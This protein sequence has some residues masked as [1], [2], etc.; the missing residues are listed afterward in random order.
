MLFK[1]VRH[2]SLFA[3]IFAVGLTF[4]Y[5]RFAVTP[6]A[7]SLVISYL[8]MPIV[9]FFE[10]FKVSRSITAIIIIF[11]IL[12][13]GFYAFA[14]L[15][16][17]LIEKV[18]LFAENLNS[19]ALKIDNLKAFLSYHF[20][21]LGAQRITDMQNNIIEVLKN[22][23]Q[24]D[25]SYIFSKIKKSG[26]L[27]VNVVIVLIPCPVI[28][29]FMLRDWQKMFNRIN[30][31]IP[32]R[33]VHEFIAITDDMS[34]TLARYLRGQ[35]QVCLILSIFYSI[36]LYLIGLNFGIPLGILTGVL[37]FIP[38]IGVIISATAITLV[39]SMQFGDAYHVLMVLGVVLA[40]QAIDGSLI[41]PRIIGGKVNIHPTWIIF[42]LFAS[43]VLFGVV[44]A[45]FALPITACGSVI[46]KFIIKKYQQSGYYNYTIE[47][48]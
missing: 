9:N 31:A 28:I 36:P 44:G 15:M 32:R 38:Y 24:I 18:T 39:A 17:F 4:Y 23:F 30:N 45:I 25:F 16:P 1:E 29:F 27:A 43:V 42:G 37:A 6:F 40:G 41:T 19:Q 35:M 34:A 5:L 33:Y 8:T 3:L 26:S 14:T 48:N 7:I 12:L 46:I 11:A 20:G 10:K 21:E 13:C 22:F 2:L 47:S